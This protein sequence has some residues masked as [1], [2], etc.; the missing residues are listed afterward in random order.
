MAFWPALELV[1]VVFAPA[2]A[3]VCLIFHIERKEQA[4]F[5]AR[6]KLVMSR[7]AEDIIADPLT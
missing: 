6:K 5:E 1:A 3:M 2:I 7:L 4:E